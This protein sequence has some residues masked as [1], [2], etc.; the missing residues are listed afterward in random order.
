MIYFLVD[1]NYWDYGMIFSYKGVIKVIGLSV[2][3]VDVWSCLLC[4]I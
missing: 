4:K 1:C 3:V 2:V